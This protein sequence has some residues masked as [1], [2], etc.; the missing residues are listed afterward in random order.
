MRLGEFRAAEAD[1]RTAVR[2]AK[3][4]AEC[5]DKS[6]E[7]GTWQEPGKDGKEV[8]PWRRQCSTLSALG[9]ALHSRGKLEE[10]AKYFEQARCIHDEHEKDWV[11]HS[12]PGVRYC[13][14]RLDRAD[15]K[16]EREKI[17]NYA[18]EMKKWPEMGHIKGL[19]FMIEACALRELEKLPEDEKAADRSIELIREANKVQFLCDALII[20]AGIRRLSGVASA[21]REDVEEALNISRAGEMTPYLANG[22]LLSAQIALDI[23]DDARAEEHLE[24]ARRFVRPEYNQDCYRLRLAELYLFEARLNHCRNARSEIVLKCLDRSSTYITE[25]G[26]VR[27]NRQLQL[28]REGH[29]ER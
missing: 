16:N 8:P 14:L 6:R 21:A 24:E 10:A 1:G 28:Y 17:F 11:L 2:W 12:E 4:A 29:W 15:K 26:V 9:A 3:T 19:H 25:I 18:H 22:Y 7:A 5:A 20:R 13:A 27:L 23:K